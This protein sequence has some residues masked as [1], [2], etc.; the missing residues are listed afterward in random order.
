MS[1]D[2][3]SSHAVRS[4]LRLVTIEHSV[5]ALPFALIGGL[6]AMQATTGTVAWLELVLIIVAM[7]GARTFA[8]AANRIIDREIDAANP[9]TAQRELVTGAVSV[10]TANVGAAVSL[11]VFLGACAALNWWC[12]LLAP[13]AAAPLIV[14]P[15]A[16]R[17]TNFPHAILGIAQFVA[18][19]G[20]WVAVTA[21]LTSPSP[22]PAVWLGLAVGTWIGGFDLIYASQDVDFDRSEGVKSTPARFGVR[23]AL[24]AARFIHVLTLLALIGFGLA[25]GCS[26]WWWAGVVFTACALAYEHS[27]VKADDLSRVNR[28]FF[29]VNGFVGLG[30]FA[31]ALLNFWALGLSV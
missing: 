29:T 14:Y 7:V 31:F 15:Y 26:P 4:F 10:R 28:A 17:F 5:F 3:A 16:K 27:L 2:Q 21:S 8:M 25:T 1:N 11:V 13:L 12:V 30:L 18:P 24:L 22:A 20:A 9:R 6:A 19:I 23:N